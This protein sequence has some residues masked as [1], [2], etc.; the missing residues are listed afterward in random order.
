MVL[1][2]KNFCA[3]NSRLHLFPA[4]EICLILIGIMISP[5]FGK[6]LL[7]SQDSN[8]FFELRIRPL[9]AKKCYSCHSEIISSGLRLDS[10]DG[11]IRGGTLGPAIVPGKPE[12][13]LLIQVVDHSH[14]RLR[15]PLGEKLKDN[16]I[17][18]LTHWIKIGAPWPE[19]FISSV[20]SN[21]TN[22]EFT[23][24]END[25]NY[26][27][28]QP[29]QLPQLPKIENKNWPQSPIDYFILAPLEKLDLN[30]S[31]PAANRE[32]IRRITFDLI[33]LPP[34]P[35]EIDVYLND[36]SP[37]AWTKLVDRLLGSPHYGERWGRHWL[38]VAR[39]AEDDIF[40][41]EG[42]SEYLNAWR[43]RDWVIG[44]FN[45]DMP[46]DLF[47]KSQIAG[48]LL[49]TEN[50]EKLLA[51]TGFLG[52]GI[53]YYNVLE[54][55]Q[56]RADER[57]DRI[58]AITRGFL[59]LTVGCARC[60]DHKYDPIAFEDYWAL[61]G[62]MAS[63]IYK[64]YPLS[65]PEVVETYKKHEKNVK[66]MES[67]I[68]DFLNQ[69]S[70]QL[71][72]MLA[73]KTSR[74]LIATWKLLKNPNLSF[75]TLAQ[76]EEID[77][78]LLEGWFKY[79]TSYEK[80]HPYLK[81][82]DKLRT[83]GGSLERVQTIAADFQS[84]A[85]TIFSEKK[86]Q[87][88]KN[89]IILE[90]NKPKKNPN[91]AY[92]P[93]GF[94]PEEGC[95]IC[96]V[97]IEP[98]DR[99]KYILWLDLFGNTDL[100]NSFMKEEFGLFRL[101]GKNLERFLE[102]EWKIYLDTLRSQLDD[103]KKS[104]PPKYAYIHGMTDSPRPQD[105]QV[106]VR[107]NPYDLGV[108]T[109]RQFLTVL[110]KE[111]PKPFKNGSG[112]LQLAESIANQSLT[113]R[114]I[115]NRIWQ[116]H[117]G[118]GIVQ[119]P[120]NFGRLGESPS[121]PELLEY[122]T[123]HFI[124]HNYS[125]KALH[126]EILQ[127]ATYQQSSQNS[128]AHHA[129]DPEN[130]WLWRTNR[131]RLDAES[132][133]DSILSVSGRM[134]SSIGGASVNLSKDESRRTVYGQVKRSKVANVLTLFD[135]PDPSLSSQQR[136][137]TNIPSQRL[138]FLNSDLVWNQAGVLAKSLNLDEKPIGSQTVNEVYQLMFGRK[139]SSSEITLAMNFMNPNNLYSK[140]QLIALQQYLQILMSS[141]EFFFI[142]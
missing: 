77:Q 2:I 6:N 11:L 43:Y 62:I 72:E 15:M 30:P 112:R 54:P 78:E 50:R 140:H 122:L 90:S 33:G 19:N 88:E 52:L 12:K 4:G 87:D 97:A 36:K 102:G 69:Q 94:L 85:L 101:Q 82:W 38:D 32:L 24:S 98:I 63:T 96:E 55:P 117:F 104:E 124:Q 110:T 125:I 139:P 40:G 23:I 21:K 7:F 76:S 20:S 137:V 113:A 99:E 37:Q 47:V 105:S 92:L 116:H 68:K 109:P 60:H 67:S 86:I 89:K 35:S 128:A 10:R 16:E 44:T 26:W 133:R 66:G 57:F 126:R 18:D 65:P 56:A 83:E 123:H 51:G 107:G 84:L 91:V 74:Y 100:T 79:L 48:D 138:F 13:S 127:S 41:P 31:Q 3:K 1:L 141:N 49:Q 81:E 17:V 29:V 135:F 46:F 28:F 80:Q 114:V 5:F 25:K 9:L 130:R 134:N 53:W 108:K 103:L 136:L 71:S 70:I 73:W 8:D 118:Q 14:Q 45:D 93:N 58:D 75:S 119:T 121:H 22:Q 27:A 42:N 132:L 34:T 61:D 106:H 115:V 129:K 59:G 142:D 95:G 39:Y 120:S 111:K 131:R 64:E